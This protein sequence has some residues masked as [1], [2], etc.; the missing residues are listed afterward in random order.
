MRNMRYAV[1]ISVKGRLNYRETI[2]NMLKHSR[3]ISLRA[4]RESSRIYVKTSSKISIFIITD[5]NFVPLDSN[6]KNKFLAS[7]KRKKRS[8]NG[9]K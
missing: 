9:G 7:V 3:D 8:I 5:S 1:V 6:W 4:P 2:Y